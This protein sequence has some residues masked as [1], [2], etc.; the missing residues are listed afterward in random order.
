M[1][2]EIE[3]LKVG[4]FLFCSFK[5]LRDR[6]LCLL[7]KGVVFRGILMGVNVRKW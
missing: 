4:S 6:V 1:N 2:S 7:E 5:V 3:D